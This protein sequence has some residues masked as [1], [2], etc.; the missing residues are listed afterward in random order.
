MS[1]MLMRCSCSPMMTVLHSRTSCRSSSA[2]YV[3]MGSCGSLAP[4]LL[5]ALGSGSGHRTMFI[6]PTLLSSSFYR[7]QP[8]QGGGVSPARTFPVRLVV[9]VVKVV[10]LLRRVQ[11]VHVDVQV[12]WRLAEV[13]F[14]LV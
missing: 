7:F 11:L 8:V 13:V 5:G 3:A 10:P 2:L 4:P 6:Q 12:V 1:L 9:G 14:A